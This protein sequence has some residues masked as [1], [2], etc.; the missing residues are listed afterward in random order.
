V[1]GPAYLT[2]L[3]E[4]TAAAGTVLCLGVDPDPEGLPAGFPSG[5][6]GIERFARLIVEAAAPF[7]AAVKPNLAFFEAYGSAGLAALETVRG[8]VPAGIPVVL[9][10]K[11]GD[12]GTTSARQAAALFDALGADAV[13]VNP[14]KVRGNFDRDIAGLNL[15]VCRSQRLLSQLNEIYLL[16]KVGDTPDL[17]EFEQIR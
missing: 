8:A 12:I 17:G 2:R 10:A 4:R 15:F 16:G 6:A 14:G 11:R 7:A 9:D 1:T 5:L 3:G 13:T